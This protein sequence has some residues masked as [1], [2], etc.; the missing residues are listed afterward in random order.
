[1]ESVHVKEENKRLKDQLTE[2]RSKFNDID[3]RV[4]TLTDTRTN[5]HA[6]TQID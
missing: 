5:G 4:S 3:G 1:M 6:H 2:L